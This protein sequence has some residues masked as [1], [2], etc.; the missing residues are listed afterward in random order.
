MQLSEIAKLQKGYSGSSYNIVRG[1]FLSYFSDLTIFFKVIDSRNST[2]IK[3]IGE[4]KY[5][6]L[7]FHE[8]I[9]ESAAAKVVKRK[10]KIFLLQNFNNS[11]KF[12]TLIFL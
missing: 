1:A 5:Q 7:T 3:K 11:L 2:Q 9:D 4:F 10:S 12:I 8:C 6:Q